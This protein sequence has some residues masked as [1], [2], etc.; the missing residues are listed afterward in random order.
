MDLN[1]GANLDID[2]VGNAELDAS[3]LIS[4]DG[5]GNSNFTTDS[6]NLTLSTST[7]GNIQHQRQHRCAVGWRS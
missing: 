1:A 2:V 6:G 7:S 4:L 3:G 5:V